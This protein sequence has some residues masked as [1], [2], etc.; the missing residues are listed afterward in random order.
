[1]NANWLEITKSIQYEHYLLAITK[2][3]QCEEYEHVLNNFP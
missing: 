3:I 2:Y 1:M